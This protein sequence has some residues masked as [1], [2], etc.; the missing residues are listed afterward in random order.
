ML[1]DLKDVTTALGSTVLRLDDGEPIASKSDE[2]FPG[3]A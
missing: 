2:A 1:P 3:R